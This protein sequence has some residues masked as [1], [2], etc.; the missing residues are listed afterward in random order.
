MIATPHR[1]RPARATVSESRPAA[2]AGHQR[3]ILIGLLVLALAALAYVRQASLVAGAGYDVQ[4]LEALRQRRLA[5]V[6]QVRFHLAEARA[7]E[8][9]SRE[10]ERI[11]LAPAERI[12]YV[13][14]AP[15][16]PSVVAPAATA[17]PGD[18]STVGYWIETLA[19]WL[20]QG[21]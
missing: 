6:E 21:G 13:R 9:I 8:R 15:P 2:G 17:A 7:L 10:A 16:G 14:V 12:I 19:K 18:I 3:V 20:K 5:A 4:D 1:G 11:G